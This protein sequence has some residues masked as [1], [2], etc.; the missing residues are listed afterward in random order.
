[1]PRRRLPSPT[2][3]S[4]VAEQASIVSP[5]TY[6]ENLLSTSH[7]LKLNVKEVPPSRPPS[8]NTVKRVEVLKEKVLAAYEMADGDT[9][10][11]K[12]VH[13]AE[14]LRLGC[15]RP[16]YRCWPVDPKVNNIHPA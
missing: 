10:D 3:S 2:P 9:S 8:P 4:S 14:M 5:S 7:D 6:L 1:M 15:T 16:R 13:L 12:W 11:G